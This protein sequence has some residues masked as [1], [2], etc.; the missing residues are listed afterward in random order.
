MSRT[1][2]ETLLDAIES[3]ASGDIDPNK[4]MAIAKLAE[5]H[6]DSQ[7]QAIEALKF[8]AE[9]EEGPVMQLAIG[10]AQGK[11]AEQIEAPSQ[12][13]VEAESV[14]AES[15]EDGTGEDWQEVEEVEV[16]YDEMVELVA[17][18]IVKHGPQTVSQLADAMELSPEGIA[19]VIDDHEWFE[20]S[21]N[22]V[23]LTEDGQI[24]MGL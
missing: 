22:R 10:M 11:Q 16:D 5:V 7:R 4:G 3:I 9:L 17:R 2:R 20:Q 15:E 8:A 1:L 24:A 19:E 21:R 12:I 23:R 14:D 18:H 13:S 6:I